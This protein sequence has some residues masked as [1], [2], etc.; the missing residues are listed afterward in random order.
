MAE[1]KKCAYEGLMLCLPMSE[2]EKN[3]EI[4]FQMPV[5]RVNPQKNETRKSIEK[6]KEMTTVH[7]T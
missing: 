3:F 7:E 1:K 5:V 6:E 2:S 4:F